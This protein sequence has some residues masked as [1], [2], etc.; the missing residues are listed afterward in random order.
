V[1]QK[2][3]CGNATGVI[4]SEAAQIASVSWSGSF[5]QN[6]RRA[7]WGL[8][9]SAP[10]FGVANITCSSPDDCEPAP[11]LISPQWISTFILEDSDA[12]LSSLTDEEYLSLFRQSMNKYTSISDTNDPDLTDFKLAGGK[13]ITWHGGDDEL[14]PYNSTVDYYEKVAAL[15]GDV[16][17]YYRFFSAPGVQHCQ[18]GAGW[19]PGEAFESLV[20]WV[21]NGKAPETLFGR[22]RGL[23]FIG[24][25]EA[26]LC[27]YPKQIRYI[28]GD[29][30][31]AS[32]FECQ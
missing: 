2:Y 6:G 16:L 13:M 12:D 24:K 21:E 26:N 19:F 3:T 20:D 8:A 14:I 18:G 22:P 15:D 9:P 27:L 5:F 28:G 17:D 1:G 32:S 10:L 11:F 25:R 7:G 31:D 23:D 29:P 4:T 30:E